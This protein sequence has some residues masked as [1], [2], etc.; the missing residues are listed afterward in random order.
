MIIRTTFSR[1]FKLRRMNQQKIAKGSLN[2]L[3][4]TLN[5]PM[6][7]TQQ[8]TTKGENQDIEK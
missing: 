3:W 7:Y 6:S 4:L 1:F 2:K 5:A 8:K